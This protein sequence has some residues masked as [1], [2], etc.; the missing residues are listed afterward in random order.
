MAVGEHQLDPIEVRR[1]L[2]ELS[3]RLDKAGVA[4]QIHII[5]GSA[6]AL[7]FPDDSETRMTLDIDA[8]FQ[9]VEAVRS[10][11]TEMSADI[12]LPQNWLNS[13]GT[14]FMPTALKSAEN[15]VGVT[16]TIASVE[17]L[18]AMKLAA[19]REQ[20]LFDLGILARNAEIAEP[21]RLV[22]IAFAA[23]GDDS[24][25]LNLDRSDYLILAR[26]ALARAK[27]RTSRP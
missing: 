24:V 10:V 23:Y 16:I 22:E 1:L 8:A 12:G 19:A 13:N 18:I 27:K 17:E 21:E 6:M 25:V 26:Q 7:L 5:G 3:L 14:A 20:D 11:I 2:D 4:A 9:P 15:A